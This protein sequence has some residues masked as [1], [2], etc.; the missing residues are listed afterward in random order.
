MCIF[1]V[2]VFFGAQAIALAMY[3]KEEWL[4]IWQPTH[5]MVFGVN[6]MIFAVDDWLEMESLSRMHGAPYQILS[7]S[8]ILITAIFMM[9]VKGLYQTRMQWM[10]L[11]AL[12]GATSL[13]MCIVKSGDGS[14][15]DVPA[16]AYLLVL[17]KVT[18]SCLGAVY[19]D[20]YAKKYARFV[21]L[22]VQLAQLYFVRAIATNLLASTT[23]KLWVNGFFY[24]WDAFTPF[25]TLS[26]CAKGVSTYVILA[27]L[28]AILKNMAECVA[29]LL[30]FFYD[31]FSPFVDFQFDTR[32]SL[33]VFLIVLVICAYVESK[34]VVDKAKNY[35]VADF[36]GRQVTP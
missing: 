8:K 13:Y 34:T 1:S 32:T 22:P 19:A 27:I 3:G 20:K 29:V 30:I 21:S 4:S 2:L 7:Q 14:G 31:V 6:G 36:M 35:D 25:V 18:F 9:P 24:G 5:L 33:A 16:M 15:S 12:M 23:S 11:I 26:F 17:L 10:L 28:D